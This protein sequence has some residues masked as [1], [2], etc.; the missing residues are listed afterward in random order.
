MKYNTDDI[1]LTGRAVVDNIA[2]EVASAE[3]IKDS[4]WGDNGEF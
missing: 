2:N 1:I 3:Q 4:D